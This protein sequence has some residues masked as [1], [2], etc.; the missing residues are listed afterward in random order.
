MHPVD[1]F[2]TKLSVAVDLNLG[3]ALQNGLWDAELLVTAPVHTENGLCVGTVVLDHGAA[4]K[5][6]S[7]KLVRV[8]HD[9]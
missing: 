6:V 5:I 1:V 3:V 7:A 2:A 9:G 8:F 4:I